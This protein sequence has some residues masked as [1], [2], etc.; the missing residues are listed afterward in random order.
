MPNSNR[1]SVL[2]KI[3]INSFFLMLLCNCSSIEAQTVKEQLE[4]TWTFDFI[5]STANMEE[6]AKAILQ[7]MPSAQERLEKAYR[8]RQITFDR[9]GHYLMHLEDGRQINGTWILNSAIEKNSI[10]LTTFQNQIQ[11]LIIIML[12]DNTLV[13]KKENNSNGIPMLSKWYFTK[14]INLKKDE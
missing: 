9:N 13:L 2:K 5:T 10:T 8:N 7:R 14:K 3:V 12:S 1:T 6:K 11:N 4:G